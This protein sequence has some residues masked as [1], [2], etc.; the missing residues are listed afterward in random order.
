[1]V[2]PL[3]GPGGV[4]VLNPLN[5]IKMNTTSFSDDATFARFSMIPKF[6]AFAIALPILLVTLGLQIKSTM[7]G[8]ANP[9]ARHFNVVLS[10]NKYE[11]A[12][13]PHHPHH[14]I[15]QVAGAPF[16]VLLRTSFYC[17]ILYHGWHLVVLFLRR[18][19]GSHRVHY[20]QIHHPLC[21][22][23]AISNHARQ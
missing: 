7:D 13:H 19:S 11:Y 8:W 10:V 12:N 6:L 1:V 5:Q 2:R 14:L 15:D 22:L 21:L 23:Y 4:V 16:G 9:I 17:Y 3:Q 20:H 18:E